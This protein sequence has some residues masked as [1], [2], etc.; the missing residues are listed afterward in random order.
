MAQPQ[1]DSTGVM[2]ENVKRNHALDTERKPREAHEVPDYEDPFGDE[3]FAEVR[4]R[5]LHWW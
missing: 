5:T 1:H 2:G 3:E 4:Y